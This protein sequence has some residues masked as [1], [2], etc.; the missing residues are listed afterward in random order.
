MQFDA[1]IGDKAAAVEKALEG[2]HRAAGRGQLGVAA[3]RGRRLAGALAHP[4][5]Y[6]PAGTKVRVDAK[7]YGVKFG[8][9]AYGAQDSR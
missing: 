7:L 4:K 3:R 2:H 1:S 5:E 8:D 6:Y 9:G